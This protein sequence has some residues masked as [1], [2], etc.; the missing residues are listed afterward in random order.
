MRLLLDTHTFLWAITDDPMLGPLTL[1]SAD[2][3]FAAY[4]CPLQDARA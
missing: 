1:L 4:R 3:A 2:A